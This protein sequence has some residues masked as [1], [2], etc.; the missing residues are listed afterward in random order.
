LLKL[1]SVKNK[2][3]FGASA[4]VLATALI[5]ISYSVVTMR[6][7]MLHAAMND[8]LNL[9]RSEAINIE[10]RLMGVLYTARVLAQNLSAVKDEDIQLDIDR[11]RILDILRMTLVENPTFVGVYTCWEPDGFDG[12]DKGYVSEKGHD[13]TG[14][15]A[16]YFQMDTEG[17]PEVVPLLTLSSHAKDKIP[18]RWYELPKTTMKE[19]IL[20]PFTK[21]F[22][23]ENK[24]ITTISVPI[25]A[26]DQFYGVVGIDISLEFMQAMADDLN[27]YDHTGK[28]MIISNNGI[29]VSMSKDADMIGKHMKELH[30]DYENVL[31]IIQ[32]KTETVEFMD[33]YVEVYTPISIGDTSTHWSVNTLLPEKKVTEKA[34]VLMVKM[35]VI[36]IACMIVALFVLWYLAG[37]IVNPVSKVV[38]LSHALAKGDLSQKL[39]IELKDEIGSMAKALNDSCDNLRTMISQVAD[40]SEIQAS[41]SQEMSSVSSQMATTSEELSVQTDTV[42]AVTEQ[43][44][45]NVSTMASAAEEMNVNIQGISSTAEEISQNMNSIASSVEEMTSSIENVALSAKDG[46]EVANQ[47]MDMSDTAT[48]T[49]NTLS[50]AAKEIGEVTSLI[51]RIAEQT[52]L[53][54]LNATIEAASAGDAGKGFSVVAN[55]IKELAIKSGQAANDIANKVKGVQENS[56][57]AV[58]VIAGISDVISRMNESSAEISKSVEEQTS[59]SMEISGS[60]QQITS[61]VAN[62]ATSITELSRGSGD[63]SQS[64]AETAKSVNEVSANIQGI[65]KAAD[66]TN[67]SAQQVKQTAEEIARV[68]S[69]L[70][71]LAGKFT[72]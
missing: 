63:V 51:K 44:S 36:S 16:P 59:T 35:I 37:T 5:I 32:N 62:I 7:N 40:Y 43:M 33:E 48:L 11:D 64:S 38:D 68:A 60:V 15:F 52:N 28:M 3:G 21:T 27:I 12:M 39:H 47:A 46:S 25:I 67:S 70:H 69:R 34:T 45:A 19:S 50:L 55:E 26:N 72:V 29:I 14:R 42:A 66:E 61:G 13:E 24:L 1:K 31:G 53:L 20:E 58:E 10:S 71:E 2:I 4:C 9:T 23:G 41:S 54:A 30:H 57:S 65:S 56:S 17:K 18:G 8:T 6:S 22:A 49:M